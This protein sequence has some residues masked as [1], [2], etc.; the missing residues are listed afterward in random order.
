M[1]SG[2]RTWFHM[3]GGLVLH[4]HFTGVETE[5]HLDSP[6]ACIVH[7]F[8]GESGTAGS[9][10]RILSNFHCIRWKV[11]SYSADDGCICESLNVPLSKGNMGGVNS[12]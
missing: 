11:P 5:A 4:L 3:P 12:E 1:L 10:T 9:L 8:S 7:W 6:V 2:F